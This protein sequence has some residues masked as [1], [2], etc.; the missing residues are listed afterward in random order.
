MLLK[1]NCHK[2]SV[3]INFNNFG[4]ILGHVFCLLIYLLS[5]G[6][7]I[8]F[9]KFYIF[10]KTLTMKVFLGVTSVNVIVSLSSQVFFNTKITRHRAQERA[11]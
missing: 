1:G 11:Q 7:L 9:L 4:E 6:S 10:S 5:L 2:K 3:K 8:S